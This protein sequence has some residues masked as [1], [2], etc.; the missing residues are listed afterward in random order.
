MVNKTIQILSTI[1][2]LGVCLSR[3]QDVG[4]EILSTMPSLKLQDHKQYDVTV[5][6]TISSFPDHVGEQMYGVA[7]YRNENDT[8]RMYKA[9]YGTE[10]VFD[11]AF[12]KWEN[13]STVAIRLHNTKDKKDLVFKV[14]GHGNTTGLD[15]ED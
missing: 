9:Y 13:D 15:T 4:I 2:V 7:F 3:S 11:R 14:H 5:Y 12:F 6:K 10:N 8:L 1:L